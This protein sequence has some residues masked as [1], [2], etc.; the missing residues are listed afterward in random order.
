MAELSGSDSGTTS[1]ALFDV[2]GDIGLNDYILPFPAALDNLPCGECKTAMVI[3]VSK[4]GRPFYGCPRY[5]ECGG[6]HGAHLDGRP[7]GVPADKATRKARIEAHKYFDFLW[8]P[9]VEGKEPRM[10]RP[11]AYAWMR[12]KLKLSEKEAHFAKFTL[13]QCE[14]CVKAIKQAYPGVR[15]IWDRLTEDSF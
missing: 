3:R 13:S 1:E 5:P 14:E 4:A 10:T 7:Y 12:K 11:Q 2:V 15:S 9:P 6:T 8:K